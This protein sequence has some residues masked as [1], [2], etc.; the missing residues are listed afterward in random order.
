MYSE[1]LK[2]EKLYVNQSNM[3]LPGIEVGEDRIV[4]LIDRFCTKEDVLYVPT[5]KLFELFDEYCDEVGQSRIN[6]MTLGRVFRKHFGLT[7]KKARKG[8]SLFWVYVSAD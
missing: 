8:K 4:E 1:K 7:R 5:P 3:R 6:H 2:L